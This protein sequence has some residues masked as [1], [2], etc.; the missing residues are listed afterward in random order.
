MRYLPVCRRL[1]LAWTLLPVVAPAHVADAPLDAGVPTLTWNADPLVISLLGLGGLLYL[2]GYAKLR[3]RSQ[4]GR[5]QRRLQ[6][7]AFAGGWLTLTAALV[8]PLDAL[9][10]L[11]FSAHMLQH[12]L[13]MIVAAP[14]LVLGRPLAIWLWAFGPRSRAAIGRA[15]RSHGVAT[16]WGWLTAPIVA[17]A[18]HAAAL[19]VWHLPR[20]FEAALHHSAVHA[21]QHWS[22]FL[23]ASLFWWTV[24]GVNRLGHAGAHAML[25]LF[26][27]MVHTGALGALLTLAPVIWYPSYAAGSAWGFD[28]LDDQRLGG[29]V[30]WVPGGLAYVLGGLA[31]AARW[32][33]RREAPASLETAPSP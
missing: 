6:G 13:L 33:V 3:A 7:A 26:T 20:L 5:H 1:P 23:S 2:V 19:W 10:S 25:S 12:E 4:Q 17:W 31:V 8:S 24:L 32:L 21:L 28:P 9:G 15:V 27:T 16:A 29:L 30:M 18:L 11:L 22:F 14:L